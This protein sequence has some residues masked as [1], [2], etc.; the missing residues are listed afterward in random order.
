[1]VDDNADR[2]HK[3][4]QQPVPERDIEPLWPPE[5]LDGGADAPPWAAHSPTS[6]NAAP[7]SP[8]DYP[9][10]TGGVPPPG[11]WTSAD[12]SGT[13]AAGQDLSLIHI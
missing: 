6:A 3:P 13:W 12:Q 8:A 4:G 9:S 10:L 2:V 7:P 5:Q 1:M 11:G